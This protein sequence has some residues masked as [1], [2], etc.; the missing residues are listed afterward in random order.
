M[1]T[2]SF[3]NTNEDEQEG[4]HLTELEK[5]SRFQCDAVLQVFESLNVPRAGFK[6]LNIWKESSSF[7][8]PK[9]SPLRKA[10]I[11]FW[12]NHMRPERVPI[13]SYA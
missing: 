8:G 4:E 12:C 11:W 2:Q 7:F 5:L 13:K 9:N 6:P 3:R 10:F 1:Q